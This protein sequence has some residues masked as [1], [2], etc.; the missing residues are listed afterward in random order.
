MQSNNFT[1]DGAVRGII[2]SGTAPIDATRGLPLITG[3][4]FDRSTPTRPIGRWTADGSLAGIDGG[5]LLVGYG[6]NSG[7]EPTG[8]HDWFVNVPPGTTSVQLP[9]LPA[10]L[11]AHSPQNGSVLV[12]YVQLLESTAL[13]SY[14]A[15][16]ANHWRYF[17]FSPSRSE[18][19]APFLP[20]A[21]FTTRLTHRFYDNL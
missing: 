6:F 10:D 19:E 8:P 20:A 14:A 9:Q 3:I 11:A 15:Y 18:K 7:A 4:G 16:K 5:V 1:N 21:N 17:L 12:G 13:G 2:Q